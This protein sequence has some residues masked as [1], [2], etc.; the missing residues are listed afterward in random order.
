MLELQ[1]GSRTRCPHVSA[2]RIPLATISRQK[3]NRLS[4]LQEAH[5]GLRKAKVLPIQQVGKKLD[6]FALWSQN[7]LVPS[8]R[9][10]EEGTATLSKR[11]TYRHCHITC[12]RFWPL[13]AHPLSLAQ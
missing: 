9:R 11:D 8:H 6:V 3:R 2:M 12:Y 7:L 13:C 10:S 1:S 4:D 5:T